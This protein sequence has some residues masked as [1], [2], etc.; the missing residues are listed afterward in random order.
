L[1]DGFVTFSRRKFPY[2][3]GEGSLLIPLTFKL[4]K[5]K[6]ECG[7]N[8]EDSKALALAGKK[9]AKEIL[10]VVKK[11]KAMGES[12]DFLL[13]FEKEVYYYLGHYAIN[14]PTVPNAKIAL[15]YYQKSRDI[16]ALFY[17]GKDWND[18]IDDKIVLAKAIIDR[19]ELVNREEK[20]PVD[21]I[22]R[23]KQQYQDSVKQ[24]C[25]GDAIHFG[26]KLVITLK[27]AREMLY[28]ER[29]LIEIAAL[30]RRVHGQEHRITK[31]IEYDLCEMKRRL[32]ILVTEKEVLG[33][34]Q[35]LEYLDNGTKMRV[36]GPIGTPR[37]EESEKT[38]IINTFWPTIAKDGILPLFTPGTPVICHGLDKPFTYEGNPCEYDL[39]HLNGKIGDINRLR[40]EGIS[41]EHPTIYFEDTNLKPCAVPHSHIRILFD[42]PAAEEVGLEAIKE[43]G[44][45]KDGEGKMQLPKPKKK[46]K[47]KDKNKKKDDDVSMERE[48]PDVASLATVLGVVLGAGCL[49]AVYLKLCGVW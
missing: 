19:K 14:P 20:I 32:V 24:G 17:D 28:A 15:A 49:F 21:N 13:C 3:L 36:K 42:L 45:N 33:L 5:M 7:D 4:R 25:F 48:S 1:A 46:R 39:S 43:G 31:Q 11:Q 29:V 30:S 26:M 38:F 35:C 9:V 16:D 8:N 47:D 41:L 23:Q 27:V 10:S 18:N 6:V 37:D 44:K 2:K 40:D 22:A 12:L 34:H